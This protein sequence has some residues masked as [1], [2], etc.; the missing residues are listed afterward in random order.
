MEVIYW[1]KAVDWAFVDYGLTGISFQ[2][3]MPESYSL[4]WL[5]VT[6]HF[7]LGKKSMDMILADS[8]CQHIWGTST[9]MITNFLFFNFDIISRLNI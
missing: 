4:T 9:C 1:P 6:K 2:K 7:E 3:R 5:L 8:S